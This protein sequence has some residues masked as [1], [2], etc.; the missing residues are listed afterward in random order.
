MGDKAMN[1][2]F[3]AFEALAQR[4]RSDTPP[5]TDVERKVITSLRRLPMTDERP[6][7]FM[8]L[9]SAS[10]AAVLGAIAFMQYDFVSDPL[11]YLL[12]HA[13]L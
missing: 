10:V 12:Y 11:V 9:A 6:F 8:A 3:E 1:K 7:A 13:S 4:A 5:E 2:R